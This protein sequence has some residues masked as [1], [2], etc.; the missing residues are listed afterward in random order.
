MFDLLIIGDLH[1]KNRHGLNMMLIRNNVKYKYGCKND[2]DNY[3]YIYC[4]GVAVDPS[5]N[6]DKKF[7]FG[8]HFSVFPTNKLLSINNSNKNSLYIQPSDW[9]KELWI[10]MNADKI[11]PIKSFAFPVD[12]E[13]FKPLDTIREKVFIY[14]KRRQ[15]AELKLITNLLEK[16]GI[17]YKIFD[18]VRRYTEEEYLQW[19]QQCKYGII[20]DAHESQGFA[21]EEA[22][23]CNV[24]LL[25]WN[26]KYMSQEVGGN[27]NDIPCTTIP[28]WD[29]RC[30]HYFYE[31]SE[32]DKSFDMFIDNLESY[33][34]REYIQE[35]L[36][37]DVCFKKL[38]ELYENI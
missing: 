27:Y 34:P 13:K 14:F 15:P 4:P 31:G 19:L 36:S 38:V 2:I 18:Y 22:L 24:P 16:K 35:N 25:V 10:N 20:L 8:P 5:K 3:Q 32:L 7:L 21:I 23:S 26:T 11:L 6:N 28:Y 33:N 30:G 12:M 9:V 29:N 17:E 37:V 1:A